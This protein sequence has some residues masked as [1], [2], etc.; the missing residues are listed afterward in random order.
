MLW[1]SFWTV[2]NTTNSQVSDQLDDR[3]LEHK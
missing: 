3:G 2:L 1:N